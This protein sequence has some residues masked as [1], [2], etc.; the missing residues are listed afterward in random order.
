M[1]KEYAEDKADAIQDFFEDQLRAAERYEAGKWPM[2]PHKRDEY[3]Y[4]KNKAIPDALK[5]VKGIID[6]L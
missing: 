4:R 3:E 1:A 6:E 2:P 5:R